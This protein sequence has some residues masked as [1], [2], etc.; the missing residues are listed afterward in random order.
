MHLN[1]FPNNL[2]SPVFTQNY[3]FEVCGLQ[4]KSSLG[5]SV[6]EKARDTCVF[7]SHSPQKDLV[8]PRAPSCGSPSQALKEHLLFPD[9][10]FGIMHTHRHSATKHMITAVHSYRARALSPLHI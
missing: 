2:K 4:V 8:V 10:D 1:T 3:P 9:D 5:E 6:R 7:R